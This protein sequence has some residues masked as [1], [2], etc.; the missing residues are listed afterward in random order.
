MYWGQNSKVFQILTDEH[1]SLTASEE[2]KNI[3]V[4]NVQRISVCSK[5]YKDHIG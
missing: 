2:K 4:N 1:K 5:T 3:G